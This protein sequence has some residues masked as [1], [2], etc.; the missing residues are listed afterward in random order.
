MIKRNIL[1]VEDEIII[2][3]DIE[4]IL[5][6]MGYHIT[7]IA[8]SGDKAINIINDEIPDL[9]LM[10]III[11]GNKDGIELASLIQTKYNIPVVYLTAHSDENTFKRAEAAES[12]GYILKPIQNREFQLVIDW[13]LNK[14]KSEKILKENKDWL[15]SI[16][17]SFGE[18]IIAVNND[19]VIRFANKAALKITGHIDSEIKGMDLPFMFK[20]SERFE[21][22]EAISKK[23]YLITK[24]GKEKPINYKV[25]RMMNDK[26]EPIG[27]V[28]TGNIIG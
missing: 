22:E 18:F 9:V 14:H 7:G 17:N 27:A 1:I 26:N 11:K 25:S 16:L 12:Y 8:D 20:K 2:A 4:N 15:F 10:D 6:G 23:G 5:I 3:R 13:A 21:N 28:I 24:K 19:D